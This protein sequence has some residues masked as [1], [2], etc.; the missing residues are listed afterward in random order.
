M[1]KFRGFIAIDV[2]PT[3]KIKEFSENLKRIKAKIKLVD[4]KNLHITL[5]FLGETEEDIIKDVERCM[6]DSIRGI[7]PS[8][9]RLQ[10]VGAFPNLRKINVIWI[11]VECSEMETIFQRLEEGLEKLGYNRERRGFSPHLTIARVK[12]VVNKE[13]IFSLLERYR[14]EFFGEQ[15]VESIKL[16]SSVLTRDGPIYSTLIEVK[17]GEE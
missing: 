15:I 3:N 6:K 17:M 11:G 10:G 16:K 5:K 9:M 14:G 13:G 1:A 4:L 2:E 7:E 8:I 12:N